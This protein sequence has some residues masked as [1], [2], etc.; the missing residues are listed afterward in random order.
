[1]EEEKD[2]ENENEQKQDGKIYSRWH[3]RQKI[4]K[5]NQFHLSKEDKY[6][7]KANEKELKD[8][9]IKDLKTNIENLEKKINDIN[10]NKNSQKTEEEIFLDK[11]HKK[12]YIAKL[13]KLKKCLKDEGG[14]NARVK[15]LKQKARKL[16][17]TKKK[18]E[19]NLGN[20]KNSLKR[21]LNCKKRGHVVE[22]CPFKND[23][24]NEDNKNKNNDEAICY[25][26]GSHEHGLYKCD[27]PIDYNNLPY[28][29]CF[30]CKKRGHISANCPENENG[31]YI[32]GGSCF[33]CGAKDHLAKNC[34]QKQ[35]KE[36]AYKF[37][38]P[39]NDKNV[40][41]DDNKEKDEKTKKKDK[42]I[43]KDKYEED[44]IEDKKDKKVKKNKNEDDVTDD[45]K[46]KK[47]K[48]SKKEKKNKNN[49]NN[50]KEDD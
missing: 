21:C 2:K 13:Q 14:I 6:L 34:P 41:D 29:L 46:E 15:L 48:E 10:N 20:L 31:I 3:T 30:K 11:K 36:E 38:K 39:K 16:R 4:N 42:K 25:N 45:K 40:N 43:K 18:I 22:D 7:I 47:D 1:M 28:A 26:C 33:V 19:E 49:K 35:A 9:V 24:K 5:L 27:K 23:E 12:R 8:L 44:A 50:E 37:H 17:T 32:H